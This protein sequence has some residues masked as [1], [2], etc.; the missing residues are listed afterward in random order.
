MKRCSRCIL[1]ETYPGIAFDREGVCNRCPKH[2]QAVV[3]DPL[4]EQ[5][6]GSVIDQ[7]RGRNADYDCLLGLSGGR[8]SSFALYYAVKVLDL[9]VLA[10]TIDN[11]FMPQQTHQNIRN[12]VDILQVDHVIE[13]H[14]LS[15]RMVRPVLSAWLHRPSPSMIPFLCVGCRLGLYRGFLQIA[16]RYQIPLL[17]SGQGE[18]ESSFAKQFF[19]SGKQHKVASLVSG[20]GKEMARNPRYLLKRPGFLYWMF[21]EYLYA[22]SSRPIMHNLIYPEM[23]HVRLFEYIG[24]DEQQITG[25]IQSELGWK[26]YG[27]SESSWRS[28]CKIS[29]LKNHLYYETLGFTKNDELVSN[30]IRLGSMTREQGLAR[31]E[32][33]NVIPDEFLREFLDELRIPY[34]NYQAALAKIRETCKAQYG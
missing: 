34:P 3:V 9:K 13:H 5:E 14:S 29:L 6:L 21:V 1:P 23:R 22:F 4:G 10:F 26:N 15:E 2:G 33:E 20:I 30:M 28:D 25:V 7:Y 11:G 18:P 17:L 16:K 19:T 24:W 27:Y 31:V 32:R 12:A 8:D